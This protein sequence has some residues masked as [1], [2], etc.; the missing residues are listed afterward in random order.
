MVR[1]LPGLVWGDARRR[2]EAHA[3]RVHFA[4][5]DASGFALLG[6]AHYRGVAADERVLARLAVRTVT[7]L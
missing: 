2:V 4:H 3:G 5:S 7:F 1:P 6:E